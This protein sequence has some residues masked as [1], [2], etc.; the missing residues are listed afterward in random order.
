MKTSL[1]TCS[2]KVFHCKFYKYIKISEVRER[3]ENIEYNGAKTKY[4][5]AVLRVVCV[6]M[7]P[8]GSPPVHIIYFGLRTQVDCKKKIYNSNMGFYR[9][10][11][12]YEQVKVNT[13]NVQ[14]NER[15]LCP[16]RKSFPV[17]ES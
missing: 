17:L 11:F 1:P 10:S 16:N 12:Y 2:Q 4:L 9:F 13:K 15:I 5:D 14:A 8:E 7:Y 6:G 3:T